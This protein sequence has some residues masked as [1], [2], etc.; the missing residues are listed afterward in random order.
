MI[1]QFK[2]QICNEKWN[3]RLLST[4]E[5][6]ERYGKGTM[7]ITE[8]SHRAKPPQRD[9]TFQPNHKDKDTI[10]HEVLH[11]Y[12]SYR[13]TSSMSYGQI[14]EAMCEFLPKNHHYIKRV[15]DNIIKKL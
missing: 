10:M 1:R 11:A 3:V 7:G 15:V 4:K 2:V 13:D 12:L 8:Y 6:R 9:I 14:E 5:F